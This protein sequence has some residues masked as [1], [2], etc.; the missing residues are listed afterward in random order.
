MLLTLHFNG[1]GRG[2]PRARGYGFVSGKDSGVRK[3]GAGASLGSLWLARQP[4]DEGNG[5]A[6]ARDSGVCTG[7]GGGRDGEV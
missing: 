3:A 2:P 5:A 1:E 4:K 7:G 6:Y